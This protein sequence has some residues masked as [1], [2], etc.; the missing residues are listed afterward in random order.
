MNEGVIP[1]TRASGAPLTIQSGKRGE[2]SASLSRPVVAISKP[3]V[4][5]L[6]RALSSFQNLHPRISHPKPLPLPAFFL[7]VNYSPPPFPPSLRPR[8]HPCSSEYR[9]RCFL[10]TPPAA[11]AVELPP[12]GNPPVAAPANSAT[13][14]CEAS[15]PPAAPPSYTIHLRKKA[16]GSAPEP[17]SSAPICSYKF[18]SAPGARASIPWRTH[19]Q[20][21]SSPHPLS[22]ITRTRTPS[23]GLHSPVFPQPET[24]HC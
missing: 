12:P 23:P 21:K 24:S 20:P 5:G 6:I 8:S 2:G 13:P 7:C 4:D 16:W 11:R 9:M 3:K 1:R 22:P 19:V 15:T 18:P 17:P 10:A 14:S